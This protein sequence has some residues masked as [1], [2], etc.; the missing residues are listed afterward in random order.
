MKIKKLFGTITEHI[1]DIIFGIL[2]GTGLIVIV[3]SIITMITIIIPALQSYFVILYLLLYMFILISTTILYTGGL[4]KIIYLISSL[5]LS[6]TY[7]YT[8]IFGG[9]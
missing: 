2:S 1:S 5:I 6:L 9:T 3:S 7:I 8:K 4:F